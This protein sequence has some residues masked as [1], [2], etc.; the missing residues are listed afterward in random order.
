MKYPLVDL[1]KPAKGAYIELETACEEDVH[2]KF[3][4]IATVTPDRRRFRLGRGHDADIKLG[5]ISVSRLH[6]L[7]VMTEKG[8]VLKDN[9]SKFGTLLLMP[10]EPQRVPADS[11]LALQIGKTALTLSLKPSKKGVKK[12]VDETLEAFSALYTQ[13]ATVEP[14]RRRRQVPRAT[15]ARVGLHKAA[16]SVISTA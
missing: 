13:Q 10:S 1:E 4:Y 11:E 6:A 14:R 12:S 3:I 9:G 15:K 2:S 7:M 8:F 16:K 5:D